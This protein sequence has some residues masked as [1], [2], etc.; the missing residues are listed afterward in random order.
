MKKLICF[1]LIAVFCLSGC[2]TIFKGSTDTVNFASQP[3]KASVYVNGINMGKSPISLE[4]K[5]NKTY[6]IEFR[7][8]GYESKNVMLNNSVGAGYI[9]LDI[10]FGIFPVVIDAAT[11]DWYSLDLDHVNAILDKKVPF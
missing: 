11:G 5:S 10:L 1:V 9:V 7:L 4:L 2:A 3:D 6:N 8:D